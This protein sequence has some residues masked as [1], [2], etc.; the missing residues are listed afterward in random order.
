MGDIQSKKKREGPLTGVFRLWAWILLAWSAYR[1]FF[2]FSE[3]I[4]ELIFKP[5]IF[6]VP[7]LY[8]VVKIE[9]RPLSS[10]GITKKNFF[11]SIY[12]GLGIG[13]LFAI[14]GIA[15]NYIKYGD[16]LINPIKTFQ[17]YGFFILF[18]SFATAISEELLGRGFLFSRFFEKSKEN[19]I[20]ATVFSSAMFVSLHVPI[21]L[22]SLKYQGVTL[23]LFFATSLVISFANAILFRYT[24]SLVGPILVHLFWNMTVALYL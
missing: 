20:Y 16:L 10:L 15:A 19:L 11:P 4:D 24:K 5:L 17:Q 9:K 22:T 6:V 7:V 12:A 18:L 21:L 1:Y 14:E 8:Y 23:V 3:P 2:R 13:F